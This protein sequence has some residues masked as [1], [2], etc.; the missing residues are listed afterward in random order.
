MPIKYI[1]PVTFQNSNLSTSTATPTT[2]KPQQPQQTS[3]PQQSQCDK[4]KTL[5]NSSDV[6]E[7][8]RA[9]ANA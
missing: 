2:Q 9:C 4:I 8:L 5:F 7:F 1:K 3:T 6:Q